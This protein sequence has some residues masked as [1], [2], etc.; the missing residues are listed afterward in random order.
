MDRGHSLVLTYTILKPIHVGAVAISLGFFLLRGL[1][2]MQGSPF[3]EKRAVRILPHLVD[4]VLLISALLLAW[5]ISQYPFM[6][7]WLT[8]KIIALPVYIALGSIAL[9]Y[10]RTRRTRIFA[11]FLALAT[12]AYIVLVATTKHPMPFHTHETSLQ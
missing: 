12:F 5:R 10:G 4:T 3:L 11:W 6:H 9:K 7:A 1:L 2:M 8:A